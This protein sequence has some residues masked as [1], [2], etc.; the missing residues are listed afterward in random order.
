M[1]VGIDIRT[2]LETRYSGISEYTWNVVTN[3]LEQDNKN[4]Y[5]LFY[6]NA[7]NKYQAPKLNY[8]NAQIK[9]FRYPNKLFNLSLVTLGLPKIDRLIGELDWFWLPSMQFFSISKNTKLLLTVHD[10]SWLHYPEFFSIKGK[11]WHKLV[12]IKQ[13]CQRADKINAVSENTKQDLVNY[14]DINPEKIFVTHLGLSEM[15]KPITDQNILS[16][17]K[18]KYNLPDNFI[19][20]LGN[21]E[22]RKN[23]E[24]LIEA[25]DLA[26]KDLTADTHLVIA[27]KKGWLSKSIYEMA[28]KSHVKDK[29]KFVGYVDSQDKPALYSLAQVFCY[30][31]FYEGFGLPPLE[32]MAC[33]TPVIVSNVSSLPEVVG[34]AGLLVDP[35][36]KKQIAD[37]IIKLY[38]DSELRDNLSLKSLE[39]AKN[40]TWDMTADELLQ[41]MG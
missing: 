30:P 36:N 29:I 26:S 7:N 22:P 35:Y 20:F 10:V 8:A 9:S 34:G 16:A 33:G 40:F 28:K 14:L 23:V 11:L 4:Q 12:N 18:S 17:V 25:F 6:N 37:A 19:L 38:S 1:N 31:S 21:L 5:F 24:G 13:L 41:V 15:Y 32:A 3:L 39:E 27:G 2:L